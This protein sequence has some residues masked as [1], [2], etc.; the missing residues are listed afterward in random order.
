MHTE[1]LPFFWLT[2]F[3]PTSLSLLLLTDRMSDGGMNTLAVCGLEE[4]RVNLLL[5]KKSYMS[6]IILNQI[7]ILELKFYKLH[8]FWCVLCLVA[9][10]KGVTIQIIFQTNINLI[11]AE[12]LRFLVHQCVLS[13]CFHFQYGV[14]LLLTSR[15]SDQHRT[16][17]FQ[18]LLFLK[19]IET[20]LCK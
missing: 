10:S 14:M 11:A 7:S 4:L 1:K 5:Q 18:S 17:F 15:L 9:L 19:N 8:M 20:L 3:Y 6:H 2:L 13:F 12:V 16:T